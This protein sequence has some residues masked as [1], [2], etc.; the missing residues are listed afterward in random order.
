VYFYWDDNPSRASIT[1][2]LSSED[3]KVLAMA[4]ARIEQD[5]LGAPNCEA[6]L[7]DSKFSDRSLGNLRWVFDAGLRDPDDFFRDQF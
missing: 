3:A 4:L 5:K 7:R 2:T 1:R 6:A